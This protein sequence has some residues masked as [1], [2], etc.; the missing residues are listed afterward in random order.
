MGAKRADGRTDS[1]AETQT[2]AA[3]RRTSRQ[4]G[5]QA[6][7]AGSSHKARRDEEQTQRYHVR[8]APRRLTHGRQPCTGP[9]GRQARANSHVQ[10]RADRRAAGH[11]QARMDRRLRAT[12]GSAEAW[13]QQKITRSKTSYGARQWL[14]PNNKQS[15]MN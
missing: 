6:A 4:T 5:T 11:L 15:R 3:V 13:C 1:N 8:L 12:T 14:T 10:A 7:G 2:A 9:D